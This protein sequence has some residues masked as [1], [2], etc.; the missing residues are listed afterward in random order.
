M[1]SAQRCPKTQEGKGTISFSWNDATNLEYTSAHE[2]Q[3]GLCNLGPLANDCSYDSSDTFGTDACSRMA[4]RTLFNSQTT[5]EGRLRSL[6]NLAPPW[7]PARYPV[8]DLLITLNTMSTAAGA[9]AGCR[10]HRSPPSP[11]AGAPRGPTHTRKP[12]RL[13]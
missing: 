9:A 7:E 12:S 8:L 13:L 5:S 1:N 10:R 11:L 6:H 4:K 3:L 2:R